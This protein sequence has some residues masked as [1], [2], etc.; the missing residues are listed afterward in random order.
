M[1]QHCGGKYEPGGEGTSGQSSRE[2]HRGYG[3]MTTG[4]QPLGCSLAKGTARIEE[5]QR[6]GVPRGARA[7][8]AEAA[9]NVSDPQR[10]RVKTRRS[11]NTESSCSLNVW[12]G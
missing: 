6:G 8:M 7:L 11:R 10:P 1:T 2:A 3:L 4:C 5:T 9:F 12:E